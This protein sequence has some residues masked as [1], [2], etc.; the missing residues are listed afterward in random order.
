VEIYILMNGLTGSPIA[1]FWTRETADR[2]AKHW[3]VGVEAYV[4]PVEIQPLGQLVNAYFRHRKLVDPDAMQALMFLFSEMGELSDAVVNQIKD[5]VRNH[6]HS[7]DNVADE[8][9]DVLMMLIKTAEKLEVDPLQ[10]MLTKWRR[11]GWPGG[12]DG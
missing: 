4:E 12:S 1:A 7:Q 3:M 11:R 6:D 5:W 2:E 9:G 8:I 10:A